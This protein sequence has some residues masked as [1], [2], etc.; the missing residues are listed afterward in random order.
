MSRL[1]DL[2]Y[3]CEY[4]FVRLAALGMGMMPL[5]AATA[6]AAAV[7]GWAGPWTKLHE[8]AKANLAA[9]FPE[10]TDDE[11]SRILAGMWRHTGRTIGETLMMERIL[12]DPSRIEIVGREIV[13]PYLRAPG[14][15]I[16]ITLHQGNWELAGCAILICG[17]QLTGVYRPLRNPYLDR[18]LQDKRQLI[19][20]GGLLYKGTMSGNRTAGQATREV[21]DHL[22]K[23][24][25][26][27][28]V[29]DQV[30]EA[31]TFTVPFFGLEAKF[32]PAPAL[33]A[34]RIGGHVWIGRNLRLED[35]TRFRFEVRELE[36][37][38]TGDADGDVK[39]ATAAM[40]RQFEAW[41]REAPEQWMWWQRRVIGEG[42]A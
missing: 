9:A 8:R 38:R 34:R 21:I 40:A 23:G 35:G 14:P 37:P 3:R 41:I 6:M 12:A 17:G 24:G 4:A 25:H 33:I 22:R 42:Q 20:P 18:Y 15:N 16:G 27:G 10:A 1:K 7:C 29:C 2:Q 28:F 13:E 31:A 39:A 32:T 11:Q 5:E 19:Y 36:V 26:L 30:E